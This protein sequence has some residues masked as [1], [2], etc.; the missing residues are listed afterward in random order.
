[1]GTN[2]GPPRHCAFLGQG[3]HR[4][5]CD[6]APDAWLSRT[7]MAMADREVKAR[8][9]MHGCMVVVVVGSR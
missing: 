3:R 1:L 4:S 6:V 2:T 5:P 8:S 9:D 7:C